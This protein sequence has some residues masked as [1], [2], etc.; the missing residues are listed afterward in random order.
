MVDSTTFL[1][2]DRAVF[3]L[4]QWSMSGRQERIWERSDPW[5]AGNRDAQSSA[6]EDEVRPPAVSLVSMKPA[7]A[8][9]YWLL[10]HV[11]DPNWRRAFSQDNRTKAWKLDE[12]RE[13]YIDSVLEL[14][15]MHA[16]AVIASTRFD[17]VL[18]LTENGRAILVRV[19]EN[20][21]VEFDVLAL[22]VVPAPSPLRR[23]R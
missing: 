19:D 15:D 7:G 8:G 13:L 10:Y 20:D 18:F 14:F 3:R 1:S 12:R 6:R 16:G 23:R 4:E 5:L 22:S 21:Q 11:A 2:A 9:K 17:D